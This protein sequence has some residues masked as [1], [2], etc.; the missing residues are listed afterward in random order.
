[1][2]ATLRATRA[3]SSGSFHVGRP[4]LT[5]QNPQR[6]VHVSPRIMNVAVPRSQHS[7]TLGQFASWQTVCRLS[8][9]IDFFRRRYVGPPGAGTLSQ[10]G[11]RER[12][13]TLP[14]S[15]WTLPPGFERERVTCSLSAISG[16]AAIAPTVPGPLRL[17]GRRGCPPPP[18]DGDRRSARRARSQGPCSSPCPARLAALA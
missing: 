13:A 17:P 14:S 18:P 2:R 8:P 12:K 10:G 5:L 11:L 7:P 1:M 3:G 9:S 6:R 16:L 15:S 4:V